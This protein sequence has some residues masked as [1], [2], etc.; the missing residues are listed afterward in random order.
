M[1]A[2]PRSIPP[3]RRVR[4]KPEDLIRK[5]KEAIKKYQERHGEISER[6][7]KIRSDLLTLLEKSSMPNMTKAKMQD[8]LFKIYMELK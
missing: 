2:A 4:I 1:S 6:H 8:E 5:F 3:F 7:R